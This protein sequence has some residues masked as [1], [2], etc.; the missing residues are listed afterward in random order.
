MRALLLAAP[1]AIVAV[2]SACDKKTAGTGTTGSTPS[3]AASASVAAGPSLFTK[4]PL[5]VGA[6]WREKHTS[7]IEI[8]SPNGHIH[9]SELNVTTL[10]VLAVN[11]ETVT[12]AKLVVESQAREFLVGKSKQTVK[13]PLNGKTY[14]LSS[15]YGGVPD[16]EPANGKHATKDES[17]AIE[18]MRFG[19]GTPDWYVKNAPMRPLAAGDL[20][21]ELESAVE[22]TLKR[23][24]SSGKVTELVMK[25]RNVEGDQAI[26]DL[27]GGLTQDQLSF[28][29][30]GQ[31]RVSTGTARFT[32]LQLDATPKGHKGMFKVT[33][34]RTAI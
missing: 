23:D 18:S 13:T 4:K 27:T 11:G 25:F 17:E 31:V 15:I 8:D 3:A 34:D 24:F 30:A 1:L 26:F 19:L 5:E 33:R 22:E 32:S 10:E 28:D 12:K 6:K 2:L 21:K 16:I 29:L 20:V 9:T 7:S 14:V